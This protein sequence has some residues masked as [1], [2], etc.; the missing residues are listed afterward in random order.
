MTTLD[1]TTF[2]RN[3]EEVLD[4]APGTLKGNE[5]L[6]DWWDSIAMM[7]YLAM[8]DNKYGVIIPAK[9]VP[10]VPTVDDLGALIQ[11]FRN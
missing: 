3:L 5:T 1:A 11:E 10:K 4:L 9:R 2:C 7:G 8:A 6:S